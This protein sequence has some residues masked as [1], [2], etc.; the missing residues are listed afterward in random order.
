MAQRTFWA[1][2]DTVVWLDLP[3]MVLLW[4]V[5]RRT[6]KRWRSKELLW[7]TNR[8]RFWPQFLIWRKGESL[9]AWI[10]TQHARKRTTMVAHMSDPRWSHIRFARLTSS[11]EVEAFV[12]SVERVVKA[13]DRPT[14][15]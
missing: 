5:V 8:Q 3:M 6:W 11:R 13:A 14:G 15:P 9:V 7:G 12:G 10:V 2:L 4:R 1:R